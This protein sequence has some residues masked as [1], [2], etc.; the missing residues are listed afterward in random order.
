MDALFCRGERKR[1]YGESRR[2]VRVLRLD[3][4]SSSS[5]QANRRASGHCLHRVSL[6]SRGSTRPP[7]RSASSASPRRPMMRTMPRCGVAAEGVGARAVLVASPPGRTR[8]GALPR[9]TLL[10]AI[11]GKAAATALPPPERHYRDLALLCALVDD[12][13]ALAD[14]LTR[15]DRRRVRLAKAL[16]DD[17]HAAWALVPDPIRGPGQIAYGILRG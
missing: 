3:P 5:R 8:S 11:V 10:A 7:R 15:K 16:L 6:T 1:A 14:Q 9:P 13:F 17:T 12:P 2:F 4:S